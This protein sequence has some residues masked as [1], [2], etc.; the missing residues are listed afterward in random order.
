M[1]LREE[2]RMSERVQL[3]ELGV[4]GKALWSTFFV[5]RAVDEKRCPISD[6]DKQELRGLDYWPE[7]RKRIKGRA[8][9]KAPDVGPLDVG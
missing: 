1:G 5:R 3:L 4:E 8:H 6:I 9:V 7:R 2:R